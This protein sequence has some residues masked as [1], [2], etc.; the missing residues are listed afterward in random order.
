MDV[1]GTAELLAAAADGDP[2]AWDALVERFSGLL[3]SITRSYRLGD[4][5][6]ADVLQT[7][8]LRLLEHLDRIAEPERLPAWLATVARN[9]IHRLHRKGGRL[10]LTGQDAE[11]DAARGAVPGS[12]V[13]ALLADRDRQLWEAFAELSV[14]CQELLRVVVTGVS[15]RDPLPYRDA[16]AALGIPVGGIGPTR[17]RCLAA[18]RGALSSR[19]I[20]G[21]PEVS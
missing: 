1:L 9:E 11:L 13:S 2:S 6:A 15:G 5:D 18:L 7:T 21:E 12:D 17:M 16:S 19:G 14:R 4:A 8:W 10:S 20:S 3:W